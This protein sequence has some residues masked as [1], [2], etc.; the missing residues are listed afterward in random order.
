LIQPSQVNLFDSAIDNEDYMGF[1]DELSD[2]TGVLDQVQQIYLKLMGSDKK[3]ETLNN[4][5]FRKLSDFSPISKDWL[6]S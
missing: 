3:S 1:Y 5:K 2:S 4:A 6:D